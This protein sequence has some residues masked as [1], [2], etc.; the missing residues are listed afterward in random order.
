MGNQQ[1]STPHRP[2]FVKK[3]RKDAFWRHTQRPPTGSSPNNQQFG[4]P[5]WS[6]RETK[7]FEGLRPPPRPASACTVE[8]PNCQRANVKAKAYNSG[9]SGRHSDGTFTKKASKRIYGF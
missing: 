6:D 5:A 7:P 3:F 8:V 9:I 2:G 1:P 4:G